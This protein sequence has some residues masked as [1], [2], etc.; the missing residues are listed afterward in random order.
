MVLASDAPKWLA[1]LGS[2]LDLIW[3]WVMALI[4]IGFAAANPRKIKMGSAY[5][6]VIGMWLVWVLIKVGLSTMF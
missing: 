4:A 5:T 1:A 2:S 3:F 6:I